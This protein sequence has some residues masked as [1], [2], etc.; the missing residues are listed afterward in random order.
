MNLVF[1]DELLHHRGQ[2]AVDRYI[3]LVYQDR[4][5]IGTET[6][7]ACAVNEKSMRGPFQACFR[8]T[9]SASPPEAVGQWLFKR[10]T[11][12]RKNR[13]RCQR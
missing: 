11:L 3:D 9:S 5:E 1:T 2:F 4:P 7:P 8:S 12:R 6:K 10:G 13:S